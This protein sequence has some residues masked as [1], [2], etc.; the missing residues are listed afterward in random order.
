MSPK[1]A[2]RKKKPKEPQIPSNSGKLVRADAR[3]NLE[4]ILKVALDVFETSGVDAPV[5]EIAEKAG[6]GVGTLYRH[7]PERSDLVKAVIEKGVD[8]CANAASK[9]TA[10]HSPGEALDLWAQRLVDLLK[11]KRGLATAL[12]S[13]N[14]AYQSLPNYFF[15]RLTPTLEKLLEGAKDAGIVRAKVN[16]GEL[17]LAMIRVATPAS[18]GDIPQARRMV[19]LLIDGLK[20]EASASR[21]RNR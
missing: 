2:P 5:R 11:T 19:T 12:H 9:I 18:E 6:V 1:K 15:S 16:A 17:L 8:D 7:F 13:S 20:R 21:E 3:R 10:E 4:L 14:P